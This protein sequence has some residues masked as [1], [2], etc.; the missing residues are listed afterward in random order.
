MAACTKFAQYNNAWGPAQV[1]AA[2]HYLRY[3]KGTLSLALCFGLHPDAPLLEGYVDADWAGC[4]DT[5]RSTTGYAFFV[6][7]DLV[8]WKSKRQPTVAQSSCEAEYMAT[9]DAAKEATWLKSMMKDF[10]HPLSSPVVLHN[11]NF[12][13]VTL[14]SHPGQHDRT[15]H[16]DVKHHFIR[17]QVASRNILV[18]H[19][20]GNDMPADILTKPL[21]RDKIRQYTLALGLRPV[22]QAE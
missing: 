3:I 2:K 19:R 12:G 22:G 16:I 13:A 1:T 6:H 11:D 17:E 18:K 20:S 15:K 5:R 10:K 4:L 14:T 9:A 8:S 21:S 7:G